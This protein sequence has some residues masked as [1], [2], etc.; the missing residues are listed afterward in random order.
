[1]ARPRQPIN[2]LE[3]K[4]KK[5]LTK[6]EIESRQAAEI[7]APAKGIAAPSY[8]TKKQKTEFDAIAEQLEDL[9]IFSNL[10]CDTLARYI[11][12]KDAFLKATR[13]VKKIPCDPTMVAVLEK[14]VNIQ[15]KY[16]KQCRAAAADLGLTITSRCKIVVPKKE[17]PQESKWAKFGAQRSG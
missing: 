17:E 12:S 10:D 15:D 11:I 9:Q 8:L 7:H 2:L 6:E 14:A 4:G 13:M 5:H 3:A 16:F 1:M